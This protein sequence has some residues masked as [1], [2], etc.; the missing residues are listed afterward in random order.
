[1]AENMENILDRDLSDTEEATIRE[2]L[3]NWR[4]EV[5]NQLLEEVEQLKEAKLEELEEANIEFKERLKEEYAE[6]MLTALDELKEEIRAEVVS[7]VYESNPELQLLEK[8]KEL[9]A[10]TLNEEYLGNIYAQELQ[11]LREENEALRE[12]QRL[13]EGA[14]TLADLIAPY[15]AKTQNIILSLIKEGG[16]EDVTEQFYNLIEN[17]ESIDEEEDEEDEEDQYEETEDEEDEEDEE[18]ESGDEDE[19]SDEEEEEYEEEE[20][21]E[22]EESTEEDF[23]TYIKEDVEGIEQEKTP[24]KKDDLRSRI[25]ELAGK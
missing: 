8:I 18:E 10:P 2:A 11:T 4:E 9:V 5:Y 7:E 15:S 17:L 19:Y 25:S 21:E 3:E 20:P 16:P 6:K 12:R 24:S 23:E 1:M 22:K 14:K 13:E